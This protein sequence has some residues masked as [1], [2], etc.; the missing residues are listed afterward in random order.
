MA[1]LLPT[2][3][4]D[5]ETD[6][7]EIV[8][9]SYGS[10]VS[11][12]WYPRITKVRTTDALNDILFWMLDTFQIRDEGKEGGNKHFEDLISQ[13][14]T[15]SHRHAGGGIIIKNDQLLDQDGRGLDQA[16]NWSRQAGAYMAY[17]P[18]KRTAFFMKNAH[19]PSL[20]TSYDGVAFFAT[21]H[22]VNPGKASA[23]TY[24]NLHTGAATAASGNT[25]RDPGACP[26]DESVSVEVAVQNLGKIFAYLAAIKQ[27]NGEDPRG[28]RPE[29]LF[30]SP[31]LFPRAVQLT[32]AKM[33][34]Q[35]ASSGAGSANIEALI[36]ALGYAQPV[37]CAELEG[38]ENGTTYFV[39]A[40]QLLS[41]PFGA[42]VYTQREPFSINWYTGITDVELKRRNELEYHVDGRNSITSG[43]PYLLHKC[44][45]S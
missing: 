18:Q 3:V 36:N 29:S 21:N 34:A 8:Q 2:F 31:T 12:L 37:M 20:F 45:G 17:W 10:L 6:M 38:F 19:T 1:A 41:D 11:E 33:I 30:V 26:I 27:A 16:A 44:K 4:V 22:A 40:K 13:Q 23:G 35:I 14:T 32:N 24:S 42:I 15:I 39:G 9:A 43:H 7:Q 25:P 28:L 5:L